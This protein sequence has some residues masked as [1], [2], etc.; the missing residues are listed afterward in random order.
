[1]SSVGMRLPRKSRDKNE[2]LCEFLINGIYTL[3]CY[4]NGVCLGK[5]IAP[6]CSGK[7]WK[8]F[9]VYKTGTK[10]RE[11]KFYKFIWPIR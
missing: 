6:K 9:T 2:M 4:V 7:F 1:M 11:N 8:F 3:S 5:K 10:M